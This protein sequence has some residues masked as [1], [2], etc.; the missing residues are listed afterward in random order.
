M[1]GNGGLSGFEGDDTLTGGD[2]AD[3]LMGGSDNDLLVGGLG[4]DILTGGLG[5][6]ILDGGAGFDYAEYHTATSGVVVDLL[7]IGRNT[8]DAMGDRY[9]SIEGIRGSD[10][11]DELVANHLANELYGIGG[12]DTLDGRGGADTLFGGS[13]FDTAS[14]Q[15]AAEGVVANLS[16]SWRNFG[17]AA[18]DVYNSIEGLAGSQFNDTLTGDGANNKLYGRSGNDTLYGLDGHD[19][20]YGDDGDDVLQ[21]GMGMDR[22]EG[23]AGIDAVAYTTAVTVDLSGNAQSTGE[24]G[25]DSFYSIENIYGSNYADKLIGN[26]VNNT[27]YGGWGEDTLSGMGGNDYL[28]AGDSNDVLEGGAGADTLDGGNGYD[29]V[30]YTSGVTVNLSASWYNTGEAAGDVFVSIEGIYGSNYADKLIGDGVDNTFYGGW[31]EDELVGK[32]GND[33][34]LAGDSN[35]VLEGGLGADTMDGG[36]GYDIAS[37][38]NATAHV[39]VSLANSAINTGDAAG[40][41]YGSIEALNGSQFSDV[42]IGD[43]GNNNL[44]GQSGNDELIGGAGA[45]FLSGGLYYDTLSGGAG[46]DTLSGGSA[47]DVFQFDAV[48]GAGNVDTLADFSA[49][50]GDKIALETHMFRAFPD[51]A[52]VETTYGSYYVNHL[53]KASAFGLGGWATTSAQRIVY[54]QATGGLF[55]DADG[56]GAA[57]QVQFA[58]LTAGTALSAANFSLYTL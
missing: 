49:A 4:H 40:D 21:G 22:M 7:Y 28:L 27:F 17:E 26:A 12:D 16:E 46:A 48:L 57:A 19:T 32:A 20:L 9:I 42:L 34:L 54:N 36:N 38:L 24:A 41:V 53:L 50:E 8:G 23:G 45:D 51:V 11:N 33:R 52:F 1:V 14:Y 25:G 30:A 43:A 55:Y 37:Y 18:G 5:A 2:R 15:Y 13:G 58:Q 39:R 44:Y 31:G 47:A 6:D 10:Y 3:I 56:T 35:D 29:F